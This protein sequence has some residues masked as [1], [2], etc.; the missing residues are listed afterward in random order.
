[1]SSRTVSVVLQAKVDQYHAAMAAAAKGT[2][3][4]AKAAEAAGKKVDESTKGAGLAFADLSKQVG[5]PQKLSD[6]HVA[7]ADI[8]DLA[9]DA[10]LDAC[11]RDNPRPLHTGNAEDIYR[12]LL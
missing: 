6:V 8:P 12:K 4:V 3:D 5:I 2:D 1:M 9:R 11:A 10:V 7:E